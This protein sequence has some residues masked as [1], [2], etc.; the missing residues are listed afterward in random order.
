MYDKLF[1]ENKLVAIYSFSIVFLLIVAVLVN[2]TKNTYNSSASENNYITPGCYYKLNCPPKESD[3][4]STFQCVPTLVCPTPTLTPK[5]T[6]IRTSL[7]CGECAANKL[8]NLC[9]DSVKK[10]SY[11]TSLSTILPL[12]TGL[13]CVKCIVPTITPAKCTLPP[14]CLFSEPRCLMPEPIGGWCGV[15]PTKGPYIYPTAATMY[16]KPTFG[17]NQ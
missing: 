17:F 6:G 16:P 11:C 12:P 2:G 4:K 10:T 14:A 5:P 15:T 7:T 9:F 8:T 3:T 1:R 13:T